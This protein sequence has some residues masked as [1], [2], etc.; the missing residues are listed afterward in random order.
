LAV[1][2]DLFDDRAQFGIF[3]PE[4][5]D[6]AATFGH[7]RL[8]IFEALRDLVEFFQGNHGDDRLS[9]SCDLVKCGRLW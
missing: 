7:P 1:G 5:R 8:D 3:A 9:H 4:L 2:A 6:V